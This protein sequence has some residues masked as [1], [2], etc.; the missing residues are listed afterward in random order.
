M[1]SDQDGFKLCGNGSYNKHDRVFRFSSILN[2]VQI[3]D[4]VPHS[5]HR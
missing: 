1:E 4:P 2:P 5:G 3:C